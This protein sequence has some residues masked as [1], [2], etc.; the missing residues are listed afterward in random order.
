MTSQPMVGLFRL[1]PRALAH[2]AL[3]SHAG[4]ISKS[5]CLDTL[6]EGIASAG[7]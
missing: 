7:E 6:L 2:K 5:T 3:P 4:M 1:A